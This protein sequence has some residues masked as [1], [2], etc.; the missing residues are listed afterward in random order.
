MKYLRAIQLQK[1]MLAVVMEK[2]EE[3]SYSVSSSLG[4][5]SR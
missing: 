1:H 3:G 4:R 2:T 5:F